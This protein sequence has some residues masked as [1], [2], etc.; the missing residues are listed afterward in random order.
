MQGFRF[1]R[2]ACVLLPDGRHDPYRCPWAAYEES[3]YAKTESSL[4]SSVK[5]RVESY[6]FFTLWAVLLV[7]A[8]TEDSGQ[9]I[10]RDS[11][12][13]FLKY[14]CKSIGNAV[15]WWDRG[16]EMCVVEGVV[17]L[18]ESARGTCNRLGSKVSRTHSKV[19]RWLSE[20]N[21][22]EVGNS[23]FWSG[24]EVGILHGKS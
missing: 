21:Q 3:E 24:A 6:N 11:D 17:C 12:S 18:I 4:F 8:K 10:G 2:F 23:V 13:L 19:R 22:F 5:K 1:R 16:L 7:R 9:D 14:E 20:T 15:C